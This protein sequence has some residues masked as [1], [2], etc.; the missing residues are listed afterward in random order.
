MRTD[1]QVHSI[2]TAAPT[3]APRSMTLDAVI[4]WMD[5]KGVHHLPVVEGEEVVGIVSDRDLLEA[6]G[7]LPSQ[8]H[9]CRGPQGADAIPKTVGEVMQGPVE[10][11][12]P[13]A[14]IADAAARLISQGFGCLPVVDENGLVGIV[15]EH[16]LARAVHEDV[17]ENVFGKAPEEPVA[18]HMTEGPTTLS[19]DGELADARELFGSNRIRHAPVVQEGRLVGVVSDRDVRRA[20]GVGRKDDFPVHELMSTDVVTVAATD[21]LRAATGLMAS[22][23]VSSVLVTDGGD[24]V[25]ILTLTDVVESVL[26]RARPTPR[27][28]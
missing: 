22:R 11:I 2:M 9:A 7:G 3:T 21:T 14:S 27:E 8:V 18:R 25:G 24:L 17:N 20:V 28:A 16:D 1:S 10:T 26:E 19:W 6:V 13:L 15:T 5:G 23:K 4:A 12:D